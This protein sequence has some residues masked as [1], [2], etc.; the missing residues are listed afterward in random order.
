[1]DNQNNNKLS[2]VL[3]TKLSI[4]DYNAFQ[5]L[6]KLEYQ[7]GLIKEE[8]TSEL[9]RFTIRHILNQV[10]SQPE[11]LIIK[12]QQQKAQNNQQQLVNPVI[13][14]STTVAASHQHQPSNN[15]S[16]RNSLVSQKMTPWKLSSLLS[17]EKTRHT[18]W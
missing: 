8:S 13:L 5:I 14:P 1:M 7:A 6:T 10:H 17:M 4:D 16:R 15:I 18:F 2:K 12:Q 9:L 3:S 11:Y